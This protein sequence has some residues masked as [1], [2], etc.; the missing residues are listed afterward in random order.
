LLALYH[1]TK[2]PAGSRE[3]SAAVTAHPTELAMAQPSERIDGAFAGGALPLADHGA[4]AGR[5]PSAGA[6]EDGGSRLGGMIPKKWG[7]VF[8]AT[9]AKRLRGDHA[10]AKRRANQQIRRRSFFA[11]GNWFL[12]KGGFGPKSAGGDRPLT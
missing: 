2:D 10:L 7:T 12:G 5:N 9:N 8:P 1:Q 4:V 6:V 3:R 11:T